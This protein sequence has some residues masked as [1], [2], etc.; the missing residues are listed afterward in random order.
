MNQFQVSII[1]LSLFC[2]LLL[3]GCS[4]SD[5]G[6]EKGLTKAEHGN[7]YYGGVFNN[8]ETE[9][10]RSLYPLNVTEVVGHRITNQIYEGLVRLSQED[11][12]IQPALAK[13]WEIDSTATTFTFHL[14]EGVHFHDDPC[15]DNGE[16]REVTAHDFKYC[17]TKLCEADVNNQGFWVFE[18]RVKGATAYHESTKEGEPLEKGVPGIQVIDDTTLRIELE[19]PF[20]SFLNILAMPFTAVFPREAV[21]KYGDELRK[22]AV[23]TGPFQLKSLREDEVVILAKNEKYW[24]TDKHGNQLPYL[25]GIKMTF[26]KDKKTEFL[27]FRK[28]EL[29][30]VYRLPLE[31]TRDVINQNDELKESYKQFNLQAMPSLTIQYYGFQH[32]GDLFDNLHLRKA[33]NYAIDRTDIVDY[34]LKGTAIE[35]QNGIVPPAL[36]FYDSQAI[37]GYEYNAGK[38]QEHMRKAGYPNGEGFP[39]ITLQINSGGGR[40]EQVAEAIQ[41]MLQQTLNISLNIKKLPF[42]QHLENLETGKAKFWRAGWIADYPDPENFLNLFYGEHVPEK[43]SQKSYIN[44]VRYISAEF[45]SVFQKALKT[46]DQEQ[47]NLLYMQA[48]QIVMDDAAVIP[49]YYDKD[50]RVVQP[51][52]RNFPQNPMEYRNFRNVYFVPEDNNQQ[53]AARN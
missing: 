52:V 24:G 50:Y 22:K 32:Q 20:A 45:D 27:K 10:F 37:N 3:A 39:E 53:T 44:S 41:K 2:Q 33:F 12:S 16:G 40:N 25:D 17:L 34:T 28:N 43:L 35:A 38:A 5:T 47:R 14:R 15:F 51:D 8:N 6:R 29:D 46:V 23:G 9:Y 26:I 18:D 21:E 1:L 30:M 36:K 48:D 31:M 7:I 4:G 49:I 42:A 19:R 11:L 13:R